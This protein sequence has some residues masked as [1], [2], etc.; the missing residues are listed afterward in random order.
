L[1]PTGSTIIR[2]DNKDIIEK[3]NETYKNYKIVA[4]QCSITLPGE[5]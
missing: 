3:K 1:K 2:F 4:K 5:S